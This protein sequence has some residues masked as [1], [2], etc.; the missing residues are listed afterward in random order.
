LEA[1]DMEAKQQKVVARF[2]Q[3]VSF[4][5]ANQ[6]VIDP[7]TVATQRQVLASAIAE[8]NAY[9]QLQVLRGADHVAAQSL[10]SARTALRDTYMRQLATLGVHTLTGKHAGDPDVL[11]AKQIFTLPTTRT[12]AQTLLASAQ[13][14]LQTATQHAARFT[15][16]GVNLDAAAAA[17]T[18]LK[19]AVDAAAS[20]RRVSTGA[21]QGIVAQVSAGHGAVRVMD[22]VVRPILA[23][24]APLLAQWESVKRAAGG[25]HLGAP[26]PVPATESPATPESSAAA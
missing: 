20:A 3:V 18:A 1:Q 13:A 16:S 21:T 5:D 11:N 6:S 12:N 23:G 8:I 9:A 10:S 14:M 19:T 22:T 25:V 26:V 7:A 4:L 17:V 2:S 24:N 15:S